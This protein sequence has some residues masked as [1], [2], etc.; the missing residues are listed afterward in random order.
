MEGA[1]VMNLNGTN[2]SAD[3][4]AA[5][6][7]QIAAMQAELALLKGARAVPTDSMCA[8]CRLALQRGGSA[9]CN[10]ATFA[11]KIMCAVT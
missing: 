2:D 8:S 4:I 1:S 3:R 6:E 5:L 9:V 11:P 10:C 7:R